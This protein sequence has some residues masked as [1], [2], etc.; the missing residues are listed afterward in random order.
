VNTLRYSLFAVVLAGCSSPLT[1]TDGGTDAGL[2]ST[3]DGG[4]DAVAGAWSLS[5]PIASNTFVFPLNVVLASDGNYRAEFAGCVMPLQKVTP[6]HLTGAAVNCTFDAAS[7]STSRLNGSAPQ[8]GGTVL[9]AFEAG[10]DVTVVADV[11]TATGAF[12]YD[13]TAQRIT[14]TFSGQRP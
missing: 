12:L 6:T 8:F 4:F 13:T 3:G 1:D 5:G 9:I 11:F 7:L 14:F 2:V 10:T